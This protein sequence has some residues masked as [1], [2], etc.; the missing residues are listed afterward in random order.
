MRELLQRKLSSLRDFPGQ[1]KRFDRLIKNLNEK[2]RQV[3]YEKYYE[4][5]FQLLGNNFN[6]TL[7]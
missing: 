5:D 3:I 2:K 1:E 7:N 6:E 4:K